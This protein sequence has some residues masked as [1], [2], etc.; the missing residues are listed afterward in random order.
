ML[1]MMKKILLWICALIIVMD[2][3]FLIYA[4]DYYHADPTALLALESDKTVQVSKTDYGWF[5]DSPE[6]DSALIFY[7][8]AKV[9]ETSYAPLAHEIA[10]RGIDVCLVKMPL[11]FAILNQ[12]KARSVIG[13]YDYDHWYIGGHS[14]GGVCAAMYASKNP[15][16]IEGVVLLGSYANQKLDDSQEALLIYGSHDQ[17]LNQEQ[18]AKNQ[19]NLP[20]ETKE[21]VIEGGN[22]AQFGSYGD[23]KGDGE[24]EVTQD[25]QIEITAEEIEHFIHR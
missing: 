2:A 24:A 10:D 23:Q 7:P 15:D 20:Y 11:R 1:F 14:L 4:A 21:T 3:S 13:E 9:E 5:F 12:N 18:Y 22:H 16:E 19:K 17:V 25:E 8:G 6:T